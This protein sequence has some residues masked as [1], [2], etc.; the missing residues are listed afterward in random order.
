MPTN[1]AATQESI[2]NPVQGDPIN[3]TAS[4][5]H[6][7]VSKVLAEIDRS[8][9]QWQRDARLLRLA[10]AAFTLSATV[11]S[12]LVA[13]KVK[14]PKPFGGMTISSGSLSEPPSR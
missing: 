9:T 12:F 5:E 8:L 14:I 3:G 1:A 11:C 6:E 7:Q 13:A 4:V 2:L 10:H